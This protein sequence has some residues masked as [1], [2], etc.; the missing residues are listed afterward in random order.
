[1]LRTKEHTLSPLEIIKNYKDLMDVERSFRMMKDVLDLRPIWHRTDIRVRAHILICFMALLFSKI[2]ERYL[3][4][5][6]V[7]LSVPRAWESL[8][9]MQITEI[10]FHGDKYQYLTELTYYQKIILKAL[11]IKTPSRFTIAQKQV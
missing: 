6:K 11:K 9:N 4:M 3:K 8:Q 7:N 10:E 1:M 2:M 5:G